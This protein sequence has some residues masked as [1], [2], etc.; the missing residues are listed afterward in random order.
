MKSAPYLGLLALLIVGGVLAADDGSQQI[1]E[2]GLG[3]PG[4][5]GG[6]LKEVKVWGFYTRENWEEEQEVEDYLR[7]MDDFKK[8]DSVRENFEHLRLG[9]E[10]YN[11]SGQLFCPHT[12]DEETKNG[13]PVINPD[14]RVRLYGEAGEYP[15][16]RLPER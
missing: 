4:S 15:V 13:H 9:E 12:T 3:I 10:R 2:P 5:H 16:R 1:T 11:R 8:G 14:L 7:A 6:E